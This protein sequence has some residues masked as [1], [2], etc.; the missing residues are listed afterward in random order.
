MDV[1]S[2]GHLESEPSVIVL[3]LWLKCILLDQFFFLIF[4]LDFGLWYCT[5]FGL[6]SV[7]LNDYKGF[8]S[9]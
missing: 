5:F 2:S 4:G 7:S 8:K 6:N 3:L 9:V 1:P